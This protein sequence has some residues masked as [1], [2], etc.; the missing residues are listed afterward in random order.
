MVKNLKKFNSIALVILLFAAFSL[1]TINVHAK[2]R[3]I[4]IDPGC[5]A[6]ENNQ[7]ESIGPGAWKRVSEDM[8][9]AKGTV[10]ENNEYDINLRIALKVNELLGDNYKVELTRTSNDVDMSNS[11]RAMIANALK[12]NLYISIHASSPKDDTSGITVICQ[13]EDNP[14]GITNYRNSRLLADTLL[15]SLADKTGAKNYQ[16]VESDKLMG[17]NWC[18]VP[19]A[20]V[21][22]GNMNNPEDDENLSQ[23]E[24]QQKVAEGIVAGIDSYFSQK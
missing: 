16:V 17:I 4:V 3:V 2:Q 21:N 18:S 9:G 8:I 7:K 24:Y 13:T 22:V 20:V 14:Y 19:N 1:S 23:E 5:Q 10:S 6:I 12:A 15:G 11:D